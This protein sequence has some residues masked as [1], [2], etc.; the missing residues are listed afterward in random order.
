M[1]LSIN[2]AIMSVRKHSID[3]VKQLR[4]ILIRPLSS[5][6][7]ILS[8]SCYKTATH[9]IKISATYFIALLGHLIKNVLVTGQFGPMQCL[10][11]LMPLIPVQFFLTFKRL[12]RVSL[13]GFT[14][15]PQTVMN[16]DKIISG[17]HRWRHPAMT[18]LALL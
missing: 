12:D 15:Y 1:T 17:R 14:G 2:N 6:I 7:Q 10:I 18:N 3:T 8:Q 4:L 9:N 5:K 16:H 11:L 13:I